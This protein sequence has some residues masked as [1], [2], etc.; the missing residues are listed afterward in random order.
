MPSVVIRAHTGSHAGGMGKVLT[1]KQGTSGYPIRL[2]TTGRAVR[3]A[4][5]A[6][7]QHVQKH[8]GGKECGLRLA[9]DEATQ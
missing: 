2:A 4:F 8:S 7:K 6:G 9:G 3:V 5:Q 1:P